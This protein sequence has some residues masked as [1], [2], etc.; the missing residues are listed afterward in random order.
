VVD[1]S[2]YIS[3]YFVLTPECLR[4]LVIPCLIKRVELSFISCP[5]SLKKLSFTAVKVKADSYIPKIV[6]M[7]SNFMISATKTLQLTTESLAASEVTSPHIHILT[8]RCVD[9]KPKWL[10]DAPKTSSRS[11]RMADCASSATRLASTAPW[12][13]PSQPKIPLNGH[14]APSTTSSPT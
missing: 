8:H 7:T 13:P 6:F 11:R 14:G 12:A 1:D 10:Q 4:L 9:T 5:K 2:L 3:I